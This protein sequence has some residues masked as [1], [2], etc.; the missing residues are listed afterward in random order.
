MYRTN[1]KKSLWPGILLFKINLKGG[2]I[3]CLSKSGLGKDMIKG[4]LHRSIFI[5]VNSKYN[6]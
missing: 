3:S 5:T 4:L 6:F 1:T 2:A